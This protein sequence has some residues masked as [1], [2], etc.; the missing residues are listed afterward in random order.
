MRAFLDL[1]RA[2]LV[3]SGHRAGCPVLAVAVE[4]SPQGADSPA[5]AAAAE[6]FRSWETLLSSSF[7]DHGVAS[8]EARDLAAFVV[9]AVEGAVALCRAQRSTAPLDRVDARLERL[10]AEA[11]GT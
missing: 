6:V 8:E 11:T 5:L 3:D 7:V 9:A 10:V 2:I 1:W 4:D